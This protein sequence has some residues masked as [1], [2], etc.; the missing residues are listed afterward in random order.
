MESRTVVAKL[1]AAAIA[2]RVLWA[3]VIPISPESDAAAYDAFARTLAEHG[4]FGFVPEQPLAFWPPGT[5]LIYAM[6]YRLLGIGATAVVATNIIMAAAL[7]VVSARVCSRLYGP[8][9]AVITVAILGFW[10]TLVMYT[11]ITASE[12]P[13][14]LFTM[15]A[16]DAWTLPKRSVLA[17]AGLAGVSIGIATLIRPSAILVPGLFAVCQ[18]AVGNRTRTAIVDQAKAVVVAALVAAVLIAPWSIRNYR[19]LDSFVMVS[20]NGGITLWMG[21]HPGSDGSFSDLPEDMLALPEDERSRVLGERAK[22]YIR[23]DPVAFVARAAKKLW[24]L[25]GNESVGVGWNKGIADTFGETTQLV[26][27]RFTQLSWAFL[28]VVAVLGGIYHLRRFGVMRTLFAPI[29]VIIAYHSAI[30][31]VVVAQERYHIGFAAPIAIL[32]ALGIAM[33]W[34]QYRGRASERRPAEGADTVHVS[35]RPSR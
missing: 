9:I 5:S 12:I 13:Y 32:S 2:L 21:N 18:L 25:F 3:L 23:E 22:A 1:I 19:L 20:T 28:F 14:L 8:R 15:L 11:T 30:H 16:L 34:D 33:A 31:A 26:L 29:V 35:E 6:A 10:P 24:L 7:L 4:V 27:K 17:R